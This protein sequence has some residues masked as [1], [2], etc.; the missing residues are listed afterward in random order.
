MSDTRDEWKKKPLLWRL[1]TFEYSALNH[2]CVEAAES[3]EEL[4]RQLA[5]AK[6]RIAELEAD[7]WH[8]YI[9]PMR[10]ASQP[11]EQDK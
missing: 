8:E 11:W 7:L 1:R 5:A 9:E 2:I 4:E 3:I 10:L 6:E